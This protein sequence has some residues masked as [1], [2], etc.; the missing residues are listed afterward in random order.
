[1]ESETELWCSQRLSRLLPT[2]YMPFMG[3]TSDITE[4]EPRIKIPSSSPCVGACQA[5]IIKMHNALQKHL[6]VH[7]DLVDLGLS[8]DKSLVDKP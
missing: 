1:M 6:S 4:T 8:L 5:I 7:G 3:L 2:A